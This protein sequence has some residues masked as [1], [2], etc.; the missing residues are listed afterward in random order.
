MPAMAR[1]SLLFPAAAIK[2]LLRPRDEP[3]VAPGA[4][5]DDAKLCRAVDGVN[6]KTATAGRG[7]VAA[8]HTAS[9]FRADAGLWLKPRSW[10]A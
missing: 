3:R 7:A 10:G 5:V 8:F 6:P 9:S 4:A 1:A 2:T